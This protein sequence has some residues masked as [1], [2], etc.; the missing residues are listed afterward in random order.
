MT[1]SPEKPLLLRFGNYLLR[2]TYL[3]LSS[4]PLRQTLGE[5][6][7]LF[8]LSLVIRLLLSIPLLWAVSATGMDNQLTNTFEDMPVLLI[9]G[10]GAILIPLVEELWFRLFLRPSPINFVGT[11]LAIAYLIGIQLIPIWS[12]SHL[13]SALF[14]NHQWISPWGILF[15]TA[16]SS[17]GLYQLVKRHY[18]PQYA[19][20]FYSQKIA[21]LYY[22]S[23]LLF[24]FIHVL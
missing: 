6:G 20:Q 8:W 12:E 11:L 24:G 21:Y 7:Q 9:L 4:Q 5:V 1:T 2:P 10:L 22:I 3:P 16:L 15:L 14:D 23:S 17:L 18:N 19:E 13:A